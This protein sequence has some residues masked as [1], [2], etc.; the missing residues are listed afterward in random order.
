MQM[1]IHT[2]AIEQTH[3]FAL[4]LRCLWMKAT[5]ILVGMRQLVTSPVYKLYTDM[6]FFFPIHACISRFLSY[7]LVNF[8]MQIKVEEKALL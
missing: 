8:D 5:D 6:L 2:S 3:G 4:S 1:I 7:K